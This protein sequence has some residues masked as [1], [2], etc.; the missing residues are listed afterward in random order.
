MTQIKCARCR[1]RFEAKRKDALVCS[2]SCRQA[3]HRKRHRPEPARFTWATPRSFF[4][5]LHREF[6]FDLNACANADNAKC[7]KFFSL[8]DDALKQEWH[9]SVWMNPPYGRRIGAWVKKA[10]EASKNGARVVCLL[11]AS[12]DT[13]WWHDYVAKAQEVRFV[14]GRLKFGDSNNA[15]P[16]PSAVVIFG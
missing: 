11:P 5:K 2:N 16:F 13:T 1:K 9:G 12:T 8:S 10:F 7:R 3:L 4:N 6:R 15:A 14:R